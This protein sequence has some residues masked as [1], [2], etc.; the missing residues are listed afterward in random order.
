MTKRGLVRFGLLAFVPA[1]ALVALAR[2]F[3]PELPACSYKCAAQEPFCPDEYECVNRYCRIKGSTEACPWVDDLS[4]PPDLSG[5]PPDA[6]DMTP[7]M[8][9]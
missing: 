5:P 3:S 2:C 6:A 1:L 7:D 8:A 9:D 4:P